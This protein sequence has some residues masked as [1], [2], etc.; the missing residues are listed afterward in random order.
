MRRSDTG[1]AASS[2]SRPSGDGEGVASRRSLPCGWLNGWLLKIR[3]RSLRCPQ[4]QISL[5]AGARSYP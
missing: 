1:G 2:L 3:R 5:N 4:A